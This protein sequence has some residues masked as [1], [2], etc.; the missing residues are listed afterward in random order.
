MCGIS[1]FNF[2]GEP[3]I[4]RMND[5][6][7]HRGPDGSGFFTDEF[8]SLGHNLLAITDNPEQGRQPFYSEDGRYVLI[9]NGEIYNY[10]ELK[11]DFTHQGV[12]FKKQG[13]TEVLLTGLIREGLRFIDKINGMFAF[14]FYDRGEKR[15]ILARDRMGMK[16][17]YYS[18]HNEKFI[19]ASEMRAL[20]THSQITPKLNHETT[21]IFF[22]LGYIPGPQTLISGIHKVLPGQ[23]L[24]FDLNAKKLDRGWFGSDT[25]TPKDSQNHFNEDVFRNLIGKSVID[26]TMGLRP[27]GM[28]LSGGLD[29]SIVL[30]ELIQN[31]ISK[32][33]TYT[34]RFEIDDPSFNEDADIAAELSRQ[35]GADHHEILITQKDFIDAIPKVIKTVEEPRYH[36]SI[37]AYYLTAQ[38][39]SQKSVV[40]LT[41]DGGDE[42][43]LGYQ[44]YIESRRLTNRYRKYGSLAMNTY[45]TFKNT[46]NRKITPG[47]ILS[48]NKPLQRWWY[49]NKILSE[50]EEK[51]FKFDISSAKT[52]SYLS[53]IRDPQIVKSTKDTENALAALDR[54]FWLAEDSLIMTD[55]IGMN[56]GMESRFP[57]IDRRVVDYAVGISSDEKLKAAGTKGLMRKAYRGKLPDMIINKQKSGWKAPVHVWMHLQ[58]R[59]MVKDVLSP[60]YYKETASLFDFKQ[61]NWYIDASPQFTK[62]AIKSFFPIFMFQIWA[63][64]FNIEL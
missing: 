19:F 51:N 61:I 30:Y 10:L 13:D 32:P 22:E 46:V 1:G 25:H 14:A 6:I 23:Y 28:Y 43:F 16:P 64:E 42:L 29:S 58:L 7:R 44:Q 17:L 40:I 41:G 11:K 62:H 8:V 37:P 20:L 21:P 52:L 9:Y 59:K 56:F 47:T 4:K 50:R 2:K 49:L 5:E 3:E 60:D 24:T 27:F 38:Q 33:T 48:L 31:G 63:K 54:L 55:K 26:H 39:A 57:F 35:L 18:F 15:L 36:P 34:T 53:S 12:E 45:Y